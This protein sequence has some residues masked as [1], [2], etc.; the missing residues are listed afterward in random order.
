MV[1]RLSSITERTDAL[2]S[3]AVK[4]RNPKYRPTL[5][6]IEL[7]RHIPS[8]QRVE[9]MREREQ[10][11]TAIVAYVLQQQLAEALKT[12]DIDQ[13]DTPWRELRS[14]KGKL[15][16]H[17]KVTKETQWDKPSEFSTLKERI[18]ASQPWRERTSKRYLD[19]NYYFNSQTWESVWEMP[20][21]YREALDRADMTP[22][23]LIG[24]YAR[25]DH[26]LVQRTGIANARRKQQFVYWKEHAALIGR[27]VLVE[28]APSAF[29]RKA[30][31]KKVVANLA[32]PALSITMETQSA[33]SRGL[34]LATS[35]TRLEP[36]ALKPEDLKSVISH[37]SRVSTIL[38]PQGDKIEWPSPPIS[39]MGEKFFRCPYCKTLCPQ[40]YLSQDAW[41]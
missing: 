39:L 38:G 22:E 40:T 8:A 15:Y 33:T 21:Q 28:P 30:L 12:V 26:W 14:K 34:T 9:Y 2:F 29:E 5:P 41:R 36:D 23:A 11:E 32:S 17:N 35:A 19:Q 1:F 24:A 6:T 10:C 7:Y 18:L 4:I 20:Q 13:V 31:G 27:P 25:P 37:Q 3:L 16:Y